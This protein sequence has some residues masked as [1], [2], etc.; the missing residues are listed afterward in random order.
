MPTFCRLSRLL[1]TQSTLG[2]F[3]MPTKKKPQSY[4]FCGFWG[5]PVSS[6]DRAKT[7]Y[8]SKDSTLCGCWF[9]W[10]SMAVAACWMIWFFDKLVD[11]VA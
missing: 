7:D 8:F 3:P 1:D 4:C 10:A 11:A 6:A 2:I 5:W 9:A